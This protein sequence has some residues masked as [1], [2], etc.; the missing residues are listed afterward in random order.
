M[1]NKIFMVVMIAI[2]A[3][4]PMKSASALGP[5][6]HRIVAKIAEDNLDPDV[7]RY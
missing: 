6:G 7:K 1:I 2:L 3:N 5:N 4:L